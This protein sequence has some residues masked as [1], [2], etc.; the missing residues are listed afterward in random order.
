M[1]LNKY[2]KDRYKPQVAWYDGKAQT[3]KRWSN[4][5]QITIIVFAAVTPIL[6][7]LKQTTLTI[8]TSSIVAIASG[9]MKYMKVE[10]HWHSYRTIC[11]TLKKEKH[12]HDFKI[13]EYEMAKDRD[14]LFVNRVESIISKEN[15]QWLTTMKKKEQ[16]K[17][18]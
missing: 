3:Y 6:A 17:S 12:Y 2:I 10:D 18:R 8:I 7:A 9:L 16:T 5:L 11:E 1:S 15:T 4:I 14:K 13:G